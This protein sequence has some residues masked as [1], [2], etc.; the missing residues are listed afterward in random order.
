MKKAF[1]F[2]LLLASVMPEPARAE[3]P[4]HFQAFLQF[5]TRVRLYKNIAYVPNGNERQKLDVYVPQNSGGLMPLIV[6]IHGGGWMAGSKNN[7]PPLPWTR[8]GYVVAS[9]DYRL[10]QDAKFP[11]QIED[12]KAAIRWLRIHANKYG[13]DEDH[14]VAWGGSAGGHLASLLGTAGDVPEWE[15]GVPSVSS[16]VQAVIDWYGRAD[17]ARVATDPTWAN[18]PSALL[19]GGCGKKFAEL[20]KEASPIV[21]V[22]KDDPPFLIMHGTKDTVVPYRQSQAFEGALEETGVESHLVTLVGAGHGGR[23]FLSCEK[24]K[25]IDAFLEKHLA[26]RKTADAR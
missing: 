6:W 12:C 5:P 7:C 22:S 23:E 1:F 15:E 19:L 9:I 2:L 8:K 24:V 11:A 4:T 13:I 20:A 10:S 16:R 18:S 3:E 25:R 26:P 14:I 21:Y 17:L